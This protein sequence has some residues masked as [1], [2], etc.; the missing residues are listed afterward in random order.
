M[1]FGLRWSRQGSAAGTSRA[2]DYL[3]NSGTWTQR[4]PV[5]IP[6]IYG[7]PPAIGTTLVFRNQVWINELLGRVYPM[8]NVRPNG[9]GAIMSMPKNAGIGADGQG[10]VPPAGTYFDGVG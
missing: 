10:Q 5:G 3:G 8:P 6:G 1:A 7:Y 2:P 4:G 9:T